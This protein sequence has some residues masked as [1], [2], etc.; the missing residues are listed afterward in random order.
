MS[1]CGAA[2]QN[3]SLMNASITGTTDTIS[4]AGTGLNVRELES[5]QK[6][7]QFPQSGPSDEPLSGAPGTAG[8]DKP[9]IDK[10]ASL[11]AIV[12]NF[13]GFV[14]SINRDLQYIVLNT[15]LRKKIKEL[16]GID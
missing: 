9:A 4:P 16:V 10:E 14:W 15:A 8:M 13:D 6:I 12:E 11:D 5:G 2:G 1:D 3:L 7:A